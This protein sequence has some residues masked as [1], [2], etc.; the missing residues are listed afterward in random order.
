MLY[1]KGAPVLINS[2]VAAARA[3]VRGPT[4]SDQRAER[5]RKELEAIEA[6]QV[7]REHR[8]QPWRRRLPNALARRLYLSRKPCGPTF[9]SG[10]VNVSNRAGRTAARHAHTARE[11]TAS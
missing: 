10:S 11:G 8:R 2:T 9:F 6:A 4:L 7:A 1:P 3:R 5:Q